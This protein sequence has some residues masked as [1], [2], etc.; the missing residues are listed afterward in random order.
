MGNEEITNDL[1]IAESMN[2]Y[3]SSV[4]TEEVTEDFPTLNRM[5]NDE[6]RDIQCT[7]EEVE[8][9]LRNIDAN[10]S[11][12]P[13]GISPHV[14][15]ECATQLAPSLTNIFN[16]SF[17]SGLLPLDW[18]TANIAPIHK[19]NRN[20]SEKTINKSPLPQ[21]YQRYAKRSFVIERST[22]G[23]RSSRQI[24]NSNQ[25]GFLYHKSTLSQLLLCYDDWSKSRNSNR[26]TA[27]VFLDFCKP[28][29]SVPHERLLYKLKQY[30]ISGTLLEWHRNFL[31]N[32][33][34]IVVRGTYS[35]WSNVKSGVPQGIILG[36]ILFL[37]YI[38]DLPDCVLSS[39]PIQL[40]FCEVISSLGP[41]SIRICNSCMV[42]IPS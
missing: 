14:V 21:L 26:P 28:C 36:P 22:L 33:Q 6:L 24:F 29:D 16:K 38:N 2:T 42:S 35:E 19:K 18:K 25:F 41:A 1:G 20:I 13:D 8:S 11:S 10:K 32:C 30:G 31:T 39:V 5:V 3:F 37:I 12:G 9:Y 4:F 27:V 15:K 23:Q 34:P 40:F 7:T 17:S